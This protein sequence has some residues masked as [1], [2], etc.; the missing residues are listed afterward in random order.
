MTIDNMSDSGSPTVDV[1]ITVFNGEKTLSKSIDSIL[2]QT[3]SNLNIVIVDDGSTDKSRE[4][5]K[6]ISAKDHRVQVVEKAH[7]GIV[8]SLNTGLEFCKNQF[9]ARFDSDDIS[10]P[11]RIERQVSFL[12]NNPEY[13]AVSSAFVTIDQ[14]GNPISGKNK[15]PDVSLADPEWVP[16][17][18]PFLMQTLL[19]VRRSAFDSVGGYRFCEVSEDSDLY[20]RLS[21]LG[22]MHIIDDVLGQYTYNPDGVSSKSIVNGRR[23]SFWSQFVA[24][25][26]RRRRNNVQDMVFDKKRLDSIGPA[27]SM[28]DFMDFGA[29]DLMPNEIQFFKTTFSAKLLQL[30]SYRPYE[31]EV[32][33]CEFIN[34][35]LV[36]R[37]NDISYV[38]RWIL[39]RDIEKAALRLFSKFRLREMIALCGISFP[40]VLM[41]AFAKKV[42]PTSFK[43]KLKALFI[44]YKK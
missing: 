13:V 12:Q 31:L 44:H 8:D 29:Y 15:H 19:M 26:A 41:S 30:T 20:W 1:L 34:L 11:T 38:N 24:T 5:L 4:L 10:F 23:M 16:A 39:K 43:N 9:L 2:N 36:K 32:E 27:K 21:Q 22:G 42:L 18:E 28:Q 25:S 40:F 33:D 35:N 6:D 37:L 14:A 17:K 7:S 3:Y